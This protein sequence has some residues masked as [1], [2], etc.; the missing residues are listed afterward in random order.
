MRRSIEQRTVVG[1]ACADLGVR[2]VQVFGRL[3][4]V[5]DLVGIR[6]R[7]IRRLEVQELGRA[8][9]G[10]AALDEIVV[11]VC[12]HRRV[13]VQQHDPQQH[14]GPGRDNQQ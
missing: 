11:G 3:L 1:R 14:Q 13:A 6:G 7:R 8:D 12:E 10:G 4:G 2:H 5:G 9:D